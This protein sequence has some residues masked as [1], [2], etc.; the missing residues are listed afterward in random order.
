MLDLSK[1][2]IVKRGICLYDHCVEY[3]VIIIES[4]IRYGSGDYEDPP[5]IAEDREITC[6]SCSYEDM[7]NRGAFSMGRGGY[8]SIRE[9]VEH[10]E[11]VVAVRWIE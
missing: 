10:I 4:N 9:A 7:V 11:S 3:E 8:G 5:E 1:A 2:K 6:Y